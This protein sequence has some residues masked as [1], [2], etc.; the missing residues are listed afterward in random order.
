MNNKEEI[1]KQIDIENFIWIIYL[2]I[3]FLCFISND[4]EKQ[5][6]ETNNSDAKE[7]YRL[8]NIIIFSIV[9]LVYIYYFLG[10]YNSVI[11]L[12]DTD[13][14]NAKLFNTLNFVASLLVVIAGG[15]F[16]YIAVSDDDLTT[17]IAFS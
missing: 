6:Y 16:L 3:I 8:L 15:I 2:G 11:N 7:S 14:G 12:K 4:F 10:S 5:Y 17:E 13:S 1:I 9:F